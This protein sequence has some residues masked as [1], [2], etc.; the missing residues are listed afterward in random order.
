[1][2][3]YSCSLSLRLQLDPAVSLMHHILTKMLP[4]LLGVQEPEKMPFSAGL[5]P[6]KFVTVH[7]QVLPNIKRMNPNYS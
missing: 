3:S 4:L 6:F 1:M 5:Y 2:H 7:I